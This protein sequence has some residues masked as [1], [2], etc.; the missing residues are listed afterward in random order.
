MGSN[1]DL[2]Q[3]P[4]QS[5]GWGSDKKSGSHRIR[6][7]NTLQPHNFHA[8]SAPGRIWKLLQLPTAEQDKNKKRNEKKLASLLNSIYVEHQGCN[9][10]STEPKLHNVMTPV[11][12][13][14][15]APA[16]QH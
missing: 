8:G 10:E 3:N 5:S 9:P 1:V 15:V 4:A 6:I 7:P 11:Q 13:N 14:D 16:P 2:N 12:Q